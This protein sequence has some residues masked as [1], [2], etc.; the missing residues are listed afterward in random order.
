[1]AVGQMQLLGLAVQLKPEV[2]S[3]LNCLARGVG[4]G[5]SV[6]DG[7]IAVGVDVRGVLERRYFSHIQ[8]V[9]DA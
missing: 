6:G 7:A 3:Q 2:R 8:H 1:M 9:V 4:L 5:L